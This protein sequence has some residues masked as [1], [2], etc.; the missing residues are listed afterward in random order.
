MNETRDSRENDGRGIS[1]HTRNRSHFVSI[2]RYFDCKCRARL[3]SLLRGVHRS[4]RRREEREREKERG[5]EERKKK[6]EER[7]KLDEERVSNKRVSSIFSKC[8]FRIHWKYTKS[9]LSREACTRCLPRGTG[10]CGPLNSES[11]IN[12]RTEEEAVRVGYKYTANGSLL[13]PEP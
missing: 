13:E 12:G 6:K 10:G 2:T 1:M 7:R 4:K 11:R 5:G 8:P 9:S 3:P